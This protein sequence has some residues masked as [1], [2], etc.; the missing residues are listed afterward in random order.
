MRILKTRRLRLAAVAVLLA[1]LACFVAGRG[2]AAQRGQGGTSSFVPGTGVVVPD[3]HDDFEDEDWE[4]I[5]ND[6]KSSRDVDGKTRMPLGRSANGR[7]IE[8]DG[9]GQPDIVRRVPTPEGGLPGSEG[10]LLMTSLYTG[11]P[12]R[13]GRGE[14]Q[15]DDFEMS[16]S[17]AVRGTIPVSQMP[18]GVARVYVPP[19]DKWEQ[20]AGISFGFRATVRGM[21]PSDKERKVEPYWPGFFAQYAPG[22]ERRNR[23]ASANWLI[24]SSPSGDVRGPAITGEGWWTL[25]MSFTPDGMVH[26]YAREGV[27]DLTESDYLGSYYCHGFRCQVFKT[28]FFNVANANNGRSWTTPWI[29]DDPTVY[30]ARP[31]QEARR[32]TRQSRPQTSRPQQSPRQSQQLRQ[33]SRR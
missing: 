6:P 2:E 11:V 14:M 24:R 17:P 33:P 1:L 27:D 5:P 4:Y 22:D 21:R 28:L 3:F 18:S 29:I 7:W 8:G 10:S 30:V 25:G 23:P 12:G 31:P 16:V 19:F 9:R 13:A 32:P 26:F 15:Q 20:R